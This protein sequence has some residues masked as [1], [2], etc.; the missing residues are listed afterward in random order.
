M[1]LAAL[2]GT[3]GSNRIH[4]RVDTS[5]DHVTPR[6]GRCVWCAEASIDERPRVVV[7]VEAQAVFE[8]WTCTSCSE[9]TT[10]PVPLAAYYR[11]RETGGTWPQAG[12]G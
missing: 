6:P 4:D 12:T 3:R 11:L 7:D 10:V 1:K 8:S 2:V 5:R 9:T